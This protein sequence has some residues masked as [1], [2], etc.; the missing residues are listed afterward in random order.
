MK[1]KALS[2]HWEF[3]FTRP[4][5]Q[6]KDMIKQ[7][8]LLQ[9]VAGLID[10][11]ILKPPSVK[12]WVKLVLKIYDLPIRELRVARFGANWYWLVLIC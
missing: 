2:L 11:G 9:R 3:M 8:Q 12:K 6:T 10:Q 5:F 7:H 4:V 1:R